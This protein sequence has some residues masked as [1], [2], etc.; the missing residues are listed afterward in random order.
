MRGISPIVPGTIQAGETP[1]GFCQEARIHHAGKTYQIQNH[2]PLP[3]IID[4][5]PGGFARRGV[6]QRACAR[7]HAS[8]EQARDAQGLFS[9]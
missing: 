4:L 9:P 8:R 1:S 7:Y 5:W 2:S 3:V 6:W